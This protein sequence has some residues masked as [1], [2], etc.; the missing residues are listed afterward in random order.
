[1]K[2]LDRYIG[3]FITTGVLSVLVVLSALDALI[4]F[5]SESDYI[6]Q[7]QYTLW[8]AIGYVLLKMPQQMYELFPMIALLGTMLGLGTLA[9]NSELIV[10][11]AAGVTTLQ[12]VISIMKTALVL[13]LVA[14]FV[15]EVLAPPALQYAKLKRVKVMASEVSLNTDYGLWARD[16]ETF[17][18]V[19]RVETDGRLTGIT[20]YRFSALHE[21]KE[22]TRAGHAKHDGNS[23]YLY[24]VDITDLEK[25]LAVRKLKSMQWSTLL[26][27]DLV[28][29]VSVSP[30]N[31]AIW[32]L[33]SYIG[34]LEENNLDTSLYKLSFW[35]KVFMPVT[36]AAMVFIAIPFVLGSLRHAGIGQR[37]LTGFLGGLVFYLVNRLSGQMGIVYGIPPFISAGAPTLLVLIFSLFFMR[38]VK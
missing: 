19:R 2:I 7:A 8:H 33:Q 15:G 10:I 12:L 23:W 30:E 35:S 25:N 20:L 38:R 27:P 13:V 32:N 14:L 29:V 18:N 22:I 4:N 24:K 34:Y 3:K 6:G 37:I 16:G 11:R 17:I 31:L 1:M 5:T 26:S 21:L 36:I 28:N 9:N